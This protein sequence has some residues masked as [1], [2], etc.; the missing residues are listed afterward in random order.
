MKNIVLTIITLFSV[1]ASAQNQKNDWQK[2]NLYGKVKSVREISYQAVE[3]EGTLEK[4]A[5]CAF[6]CGNILFS[7]DK[8]GASTEKNYY[9]ADGSLDRKIIYEYDKKGNKIAENVYNSEEKLLSKKQYQYDDKGNKTKELHYNEK[10]DLEIKEEYQYDKKNNLIEYKEFLG[11]ELISKNMYSYDE[12]GNKIEKHSMEKDFF[13]DKKDIKK[14]IFK[15]D[16]KRRLIEENIYTNRGELAMTRTFQYEKNSKRVEEIRYN[17][18]IGN[19]YDRTIYQYDKNDNLT[20]KSNYDDKGELTKKITIQYDEKG[21]QIKYESFNLIRG[22]DRKTA[23]IYEYEPQG[24]WIKWI[25]YEN[26]QP[27]F[28]T[29]R[30]IKYY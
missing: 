27:K 23:C 15:Y 21:N 22:I 13:S 16:K 30:V 1:F 26:D 18:N 19:I 28:I 14:Y 8:K 25:R 7:Y 6:G 9:N 24:N 4:G 12:K 5:I 17:Y 10:G 29:E 2:V 3:K 11:D 20:E